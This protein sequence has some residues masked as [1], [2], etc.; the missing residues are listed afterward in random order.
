M[1]E[2][3]FE[4]LEAAK[5][6]LAYKAGRAAAQGIRIS[7]FTILRIVEPFA[8]FVLTALALIGVLV[9]FLYKFSQAAP[10]FPFWLV[11]GMSIGCGM[12]VFVLNAIIRRL[13]Q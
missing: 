1:A 10:N 4:P 3:S 13:S 9:A 8:R 5:P 2:S 11:L 7:L 12:L 6:G